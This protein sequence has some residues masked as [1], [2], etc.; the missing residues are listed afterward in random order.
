MD[1]TTGSLFDKHIEEYDMR[2]RHIDELLMRAHAKA[3][4]KEHEAAI[5]LARL[6]KER[7]RFASW[8]NEQKIKPL[9]NWRQEEIEKAGPMGVWDAVAQQLERLVERLE[10]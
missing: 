7:D 2:L 1:D 8:V 10:R 4:D 5:E 9:G 3:L 6:Q